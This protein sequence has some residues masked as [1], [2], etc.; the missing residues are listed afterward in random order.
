MLKSVSIACHNWKVLLKSLLLQVVLLSLVVALGVTLFG[1]MLSGVVEIF[2][3]S[4]V[5]D[6]AYDTINAIIDGTFDSMEF[7]AQL[8]EVI[9]SMREGLSSLEHP[10]GM[11]VFTYIFVVLII[12]VYRMLVSLSDVPVGCQLEEFMTSNASRPFTWYLIK[13]QG[14]IWKFSLLQM[15]ITLPL[16]ILILSGSIGFYLLFLIA[17]NWW[18]IIPVAILALLFYVARL[19]MFAFC[20]PAIVVDDLPSRKGFVRGLSAIFARFWQVFWQT[21]VVVVVMVLV[22][23]AGI[24]LID[25]P[26]VMSAVIAVP[27]FVLYFFL[28]C[29]NVTE[30][31]RLGNRPF[32]HKRV[33]IEG[34]ERYNRK[35]KR[36]E[37]KAAKNK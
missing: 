35:L 8:N 22:V 27:N 2:N 36:L 23:V 24:M 14:K 20:L 6:F 37:K 26:I 30:Y 31:F 17:F 34:T 9:D 15:V 11:P 21:L 16:D 10:L 3:E 28:K 29:I 7:S 18:T 5:T 1:N 25:D 33:D 19:T 13:K 4:N 12:V 32:F